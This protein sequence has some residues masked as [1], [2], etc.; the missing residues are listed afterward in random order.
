MAAAGHVQSSPATIGWRVWL[1]AIRPRTLPAAVG[2]IAVGTA[3]AIEQ[4]GFHLISAVAALLVALL[5]QI[6]ANLAN[7]LFDFKRGADVARVGPTRVTQ[8]GLISPRM[9]G[10]AT[11]IV[12]GL[13]TLAGLAL[14][15]RGGWPVLALGVLA[16]LAAVAY[17]G[18]PFPLGYHGLG[19]L[20]VFLFFGLVG[21]A[22]TAYVQTEELT[23]FAIWAAV[24]VGCLA[25]AIIVVNNL[26]DIETDRAANKRTLAVRLGRAG[27]IAEYGILMAVAYLT[28]PLLWLTGEMSLWWWLPWLSLPLALPLLQKLRSE[29]GRALNPVLGGTARLSLVYSLLFAGSILL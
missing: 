14:V 29:Q 8:S 20:F 24:P 21:V 22:G 13:A 28:P 1:L 3:V 5:L 23:W 2:P 17:T 25:T 27:T 18:G 16:L 7:D 9:M 15:W 26:R 4:D 12:L 6:A 11:A 10:F 19:D